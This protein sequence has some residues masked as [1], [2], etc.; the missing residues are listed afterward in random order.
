MTSK[1]A[2]RAALALAAG[3]AGLI[4]ATTIPS[5]GGSAQTLRKPLI[6]GLALVGMTCLRQFSTKDLPAS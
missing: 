2:W 6:A 3:V 5:P 4:I 1:L